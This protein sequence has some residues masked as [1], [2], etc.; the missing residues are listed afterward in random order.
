[1]VSKCRG[2]LT[3]HENVRSGPHSPP[4]PCSGHRRCPEHGQNMTIFWK[5]A[6]FSWP[7]YGHQC[8]MSGIEP[9]KTGHIPDIHVGCPEHGQFFLALFRISLCYVQNR[10]WKNSP[11]SRH[12]SAETLALFRTSLYHVWNKANIIVGGCPEYHQNFLALLEHQ[13]GMS[14]A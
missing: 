6:S 14:G 3:K 2:F 5:N 4:W 13:C 10:A 11:C 1:M 7:Y 12:Q 9:I 8:A